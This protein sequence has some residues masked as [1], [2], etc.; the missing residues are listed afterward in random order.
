MSYKR[1][2]EYATEERENSQP[3]AAVTVKK[4]SRVGKWVDIFERNTDPY[5]KWIHKHKLLITVVAIALIIIAFLCR[6]GDKGGVDLFYFV[7]TTATTVGYGDISPN[8]D[9]SKVFTTVGLFLVLVAQV[10]T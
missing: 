4:R 1:F 8:T 9:V 2:P 10:V 3:T 5:R 7:A 6:E